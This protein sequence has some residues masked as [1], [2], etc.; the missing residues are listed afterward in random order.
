MSDPFAHMSEEQLKAETENIE[1]DIALLIDSGAR[2][3]AAGFTEEQLNER[4]LKAEAALKRIPDE[5][6]AIMLA[7]GSTEEEQKR[8]EWQS[9]RPPGSLLGALAGLSTSRSVK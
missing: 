2:R 4:R 3:N 1:R 6:A 8:A 7:A 5:R 9:K